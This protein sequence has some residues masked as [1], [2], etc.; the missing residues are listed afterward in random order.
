VEEKREECRGGSEEGRREEREGDGRNKFH[1][2][3]RK[4]TE[5][6]NLTKC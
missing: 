1:L 6:C 3:G 5:K 4:T 2:A